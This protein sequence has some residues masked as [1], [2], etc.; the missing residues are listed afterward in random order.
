MAISLTV[1][2]MASFATQTWVPYKEMP[3][4]SCP[5]RWSG[6]PTGRGV[7]LGHLWSA[8][9]TQTCVPSEETPMGTRAHGD[10]LNERTRRRVQFAH[11]SRCCSS[12]PRR[13][14]RRRRRPAGL[15]PTAVVLTTAPVEAFSSLT[16]SLPSFVTQTWVPSEEMSYGGA[17]GDGLD[18]SARRGIE[19]GHRVARPGSPPRRGCRRRR[20]LWERCP[21]RWSGAP[22]RSRRP[23]R[24]PCRLSPAFVTQACVPSEETPS[25]R[26]PTAMV[27]TTAPSRR[28]ARSPSSLAGVRYPDVGTVGGDANGPGGAHRDGLTTAAAEAGGGPR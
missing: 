10:G 8:F 1:L 4:G 7:Q 17:L 21:R 6:R 26:V 11:R 23:A 19:L 2:L 20:R 28:P 12:P 3:L 25:G 22:S 27:W 14:C 5:R 9:V 15:A 24:L 13:G 18:D 16:V